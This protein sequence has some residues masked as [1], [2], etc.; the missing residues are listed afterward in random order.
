MLGNILAVAGGGALGATL[1]YL[2]STGVT[3]LL[4]GI[5]WAAAIPLGTLAVNVLGCFVIGILSPALGALVPAR[6]QLTLFL[7]TGML[8]GFTTMSTFS[9]ETYTLWQGGQHLLAAG[10][11]AGT[12][13]VCLAAVALG[14][15]VAQAVLAR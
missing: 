5:A 3:N 1:R 9:N 4:G 12:L 11:A 6:P 13:A 14:H 10:Y 15:L 8:G 7:V 2:G